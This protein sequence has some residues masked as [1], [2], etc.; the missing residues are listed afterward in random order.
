VEPAPIDAV[1]TL[2]HR[3]RQQPRVADDQVLGRLVAAISVSVMRSEAFHPDGRTRGR[4]ALAGGNETTR[5]VAATAS[6]RLLGLPR[7]EDVVCP[8]AR[9]AGPPDELEAGANDQDQCGG[10]YV[11]LVKSLQRR[12]AGEAGSVWRS[13]V[14]GIGDALRQ[15]AHVLERRCNVAATDRYWSPRKR[16]KAPADAARC[17]RCPRRPPTY[18]ESS[19]LALASLK[20]QG[21]SP[22][23]S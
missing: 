16:W 14:D 19:T 22:H 13:L 5:V 7:H 17:S 1:Q 15:R 11:M 10:P 4:S 20:I 21:R 18:A 3:R 2:D 23:V 9:T 6:L 12:Q 8:P